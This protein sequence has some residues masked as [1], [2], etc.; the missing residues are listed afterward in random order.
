MLKEKI[1]KVLS[2]IW[3][4]ASIILVF[5]GGITVFGFLAAFIIGGGLGENIAV[6]IYKQIFPI[7]IFSTSVLIVLG[8]IIMEIRGEKALTA[9]E[10]KNKEAQAE[11]K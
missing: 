1:S 3:A 11:K 5:L 8:W 7:I 6:I 2:I 10:K 9:G 4:I